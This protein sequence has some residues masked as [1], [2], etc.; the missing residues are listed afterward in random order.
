MKKIYLLALTSNLLYLQMYADSR[1]YDFRGIASEMITVVGGVVDKDS[2]YNDNGEYMYYPVINFTSE[3]D[4]MHVQLDGMEDFEILY[5]NRVSKDHILKFRDE[6][7]HVDGKS[8]VFKLTG[9]SIGD[10][11]R[12]LASAKGSAS[13]TFNAL[14]GANGEDQIVENTKDSITYKFEIVEFYA[15]TEIVQIKEISAG[16]RIQTLTIVPFVCGVEDITESTATLKWIPDTA[17]NQ[18]NINVYQDTTHVAHYVV[19]ANGQVVSSQ[20]FAPSIYQHK[21]DTTVS[22]KDYFVITLDG[23]SAGTNYNYVINGTNI[24]NVP[25]YH[26]VGLFTTLSISTSIDNVV[27]SDDPRKQT[28][29]FI[30]DGI[31]FIERNGKT[32]NAQGVEM[33]P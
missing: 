15:T 12:L 30:R 8:A 7:M 28:Q 2:I 29:K 26:K 27:I 10:T 19:D 22:S 25:I 13:P 1:V 31:L 11:I 17:V 33:K 14:S 21:M 9:L 18:Y 5:S 20:H 6:Y 16:F 23:L 4:T 32:Y 3:G 24:Q